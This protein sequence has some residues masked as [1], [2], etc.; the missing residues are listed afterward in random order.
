MPTARQTSSKVAT[1]PQFSRG[2]VAEKKA[3]LEEGVDHVEHCHFVWQPR[4]ANGAS[5]PLPTELTF[6]ETGT[7]GNGAGD[8]VDNGGYALTHSADSE[9][10]SVRLDGADSL[11][12]DIF[13][14]PK[15]TVYAKIDFDTA[16]FTADQRAVIGFASAFSAVLDDTTTNCWFRVEGA[17]LNILTE[18]DDGTTDDD[19]NDSGIDLVDGALTVFEI[20]ASDLSGV[21]F[22]VNGVQAGDPL[23]MSAITSSTPVQPIVMMQRDDG[24]EE[25]V[26]TVE[27]IQL[28]WER[29]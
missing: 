1:Q 20:D 2:L 27:L 24:A 29:T 22:Y 13:K 12:V 15:L 21:L 25:D 19:D 18:S 16:M 23:D 14:K 5:A 26:L 3:F 4:G 17:S 28:T 6:T 10:Q 8:Y 7:S 11:W 9:A